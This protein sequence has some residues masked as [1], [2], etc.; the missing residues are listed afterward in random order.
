M[1]GSYGRSLNVELGRESIAEFEIPQSWTSL[2]CWWE[3]DR[4][5]GSLGALSVRHGCSCRGECAH[6]L[7][8]PVPRIRC[9]GG[10][11]NV[12][13][14]ISPKTGAPSEA[15]V[16][17]LFP[18]EPEFIGLPYWTDGALVQRRGIPTIVLGPGDPYQ[19]HTVNESIRV[20]RLVA[21]V[22]I[23]CQISSSICVVRRE[24]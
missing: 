24:T 17:G 9:G 1:H 15:Y 13:V 21:V 12:V 8:R 22:R 20:H 2:A 11:R 16:G 4:V 6:I 7:R 3:T 10:G 19:C 23:Y 14:S 18:D 5:E